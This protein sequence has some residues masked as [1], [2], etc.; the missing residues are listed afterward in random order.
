MVDAFRQSLKTGRALDAHHRRVY[1]DMNNNNSE[2]AGA[3]NLALI[4][5]TGTR[6]KQVL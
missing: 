4:A 5:R 1:T 2:P 3:F 6:S